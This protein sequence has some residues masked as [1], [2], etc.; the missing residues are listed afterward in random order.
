MGKLSVVI[1]AYNEEL[2]INKCLESVK[3]IADEIIFIDNTST[4]KTAEIAKKAGAKI[5]VRENNPML[6]INKNFGISKAT[7]D[8]ILYLDADEQVSPELAIEIKSMLNEKSETDGYRIPRKNIIFGKWIEHAGWY[9]DYQLRFFR[10]GK[11]KFPEGHVH[12]ELTMKGKMG[13]LTNP[14]VHSNFETVSQFLHKHFLTYAPN[15][16]EQLIKN[17]YVFNW[18]DAIKMPANEFLSRFFA[19]QG[20]KDGFHGLVLSLLMGFYHFI[21]FTLIWEKYGFEQVNSKDFIKETEK[22]FDKVNKDLSYWFLS[23]KIK[24]IRNPLKK[25]NARLFRKIRLFR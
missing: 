8:W 10:N 23:E 19:R 15:E 18:Q 7:L 3:K 14:L 16:A 4:D 9:P 6:N 20:Y 13:K 11:V 17:G 12:E 25:I 1:S 22:E 24:N 5:F 2:K 21:I